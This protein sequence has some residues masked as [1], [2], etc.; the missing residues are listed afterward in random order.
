MCC[1]IFFIF[2]CCA[3]V[4]I[5]DISFINAFSFLT[6]LGIILIVLH[7][8]SCNIVHIFLLKI[9]YT[10]GF[11]IAKRHRINM[12]KNKLYISETIRPLPFI[13]YIIKFISVNTKITIS[14]RNCF[15]TANIFFIMTPKNLK[16]FVNI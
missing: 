2:F 10:K 7:L 12:Q 16:L 3:Y 5:S 14:I 1:S 6:F 13:I 8:V 4:N 9:R 11:R 15:I